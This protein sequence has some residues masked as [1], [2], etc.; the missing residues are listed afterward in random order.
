MGNSTAI[1]HFLLCRAWQIE[2]QESSSTTINM[3]LSEYF[4]VT[5]YV[6][7]LT[8]STVEMRLEDWFTKPSVRREALAAIDHC[9]K[10]NYWQ[11]SAINYTI[12]S[13]RSLRRWNEFLRRLYS[14]TMFQLSVYDYYAFLNDVKSNNFMI[15][16]QVSGEGSSKVAKS[17][18][19]VFL[20]RF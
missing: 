4:Q 13:G 6:G 15:I 16:F 11:P 1:W 5:M 19:S 8:F 9:I 20:E 7:T 3:K 14:Q 17:L 10:D 12:E 18:L 2:F